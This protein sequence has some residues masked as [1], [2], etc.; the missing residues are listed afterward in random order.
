GLAGSCNNRAILLHTNN[1][2]AE[3]EKLYDKA[4]VLLDKLVVDHADVPAYQGELADMLQ[5]LGVLYQTTNRPNLAA[6]SLGR[7]L[8]L[9][10]T[11]A[12][13]YPKNPGYEQDLA[14]ARL[15]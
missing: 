10:R 11:L 4:L 3:A 5:N 12:G 6:K 2:L 9:R 8:D 14:S 1:R 15:N 13:A 7:S